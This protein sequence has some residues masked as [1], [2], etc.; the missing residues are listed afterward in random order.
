MV[1]YFWTIHQPETVSFSTRNRDGDNTIETTELENS[2]S[3]IPQRLKGVTEIENKQ[4][5]I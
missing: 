2:V 3:S 4:I 1:E 5:H